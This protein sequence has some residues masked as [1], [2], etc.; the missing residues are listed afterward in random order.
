MRVAA[1]L[2]GRREVALLIAMFTMSFSYGAGSNPPIDAPRML[3]ADTVQ[4]LPDGVTRA[5]IFEDSEIEMA[6][7]AICPAVFIV[8]TGGGQTQ[9]TGQASYRFVAACLLESLAS[10][11]ARLAGAL[12]VLDIEMDTTKA[13]KALLDQ[14][15]AMRDAENTNGSFAIVEQVTDQFSA[16]ERL[17][18]QLVRLQS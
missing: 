13:A 9:F 17:W 11:K 10:N 5:Y 7:N 8:P 16:R 1:K 12:K 2:R 3:I 15:K 4:F 14:A 6:A 18:K